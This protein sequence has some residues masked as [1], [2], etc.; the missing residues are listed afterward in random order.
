MDR[1]PMCSHPLLALH[2]STSEITGPK[3]SRPTGVDGL[4][5]RAAAFVRLAAQLT[6]ISTPEPTA[7]TPEK[8]SRRK[9][10]VS[11]PMADIGVESERAKRRIKES[12]LGLQPSPEET[13][14]T[15]I[16]PELRDR[17][18]RQLERSSVTRDTS[19]SVLALDRLQTEWSELDGQ[20]QKTQQGLRNRGEKIEQ[21]VETIRKIRTL[22]AHTRTDAVGL[23]VSPD[24]IRQI[25]EVLQGAEAATAEANERQARV[26]S[27]QSDI[28]SLSE[29]AGE[30]EMAIAEAR[31]RAMGEVLHR[32]SPP[33][34]S[35]GFW[36]GID[37]DT[38]GAKLQHQETRDSEMLKQY[39]AK[40][41]ADLQRR[42]AEYY[43]GG[44]PH[45]SRA[46]KLSSKL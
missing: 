19:P 38:I 40:N 46:A 9:E 39:W 26:L 2:P 31:N 35:S 30:D 3:E 5:H 4:P 42:A 8:E 44:R 34:W 25:D 15:S 24:V 23:E 32:D 28:A 18:D 16:I 1:D 6:G 21:H 14:A 17:V 36:H 12:L 45:Y 22:W 20:L 13:E 11:V 27:L 41:G 33:I 10:P 43:A 37:G 29:V 7:E